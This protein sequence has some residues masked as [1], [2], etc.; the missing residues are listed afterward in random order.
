MPSRLIP[1]SEGSASE[2]FCFKVFGAAW[3]DSGLSFEAFLDRLVDDALAGRE[4]SFKGI[5]GSGEKIFLWILEQ[6]AVGAASRPGSDGMGW[7]MSLI[8]G[9]DPMDKIK[10]KLDEMSKNLDHI[11][12]QI[13]KLHGDLKKELAVLET[14]VAYSNIKGKIADIETLYHK[15]MRTLASMTNKEEAKKEADRIEGL[16]SDQVFSGLT[17]IHKGLG[18]DPVSQSLYALL[19]EQLLLQTEGGDVSLEEAL[20][21][22]EN[23]FVYMTGVQLKGLALLSEYW[24]RASSGDDIEKI[25]MKAHD[26]H[27]EKLVEQS[28]V[29]LNGLEML[30]VHAAPRAGFT[31]NYHGGSPFYGDRS[32][33]FFRA[34]ALAAS[35]TNSKSQVIVRLLWDS[36]VNDQYPWDEKD[37]KD[38]KPDD[39]LPSKSTSGF[40]GFMKERLEELKKPGKS[41]PLLLLRDE[42]GKRKEIEAVE[43]YGSVNAMPLK[44]SGRTPEN[45]EAVVRRYV[46]R[47]PDIGHTYT[48][49]H[50]T[51]QKFDLRDDESIPVPGTIGRKL[52]SADPRIRVRSSESGPHVTIPLFAWLPESYILEGTSSGGTLPVMWPAEPAQFVDDPD[53]VWRYVVSVSSYSK[54]KFLGPVWVPDPWGGTDVASRVSLG[55][56]ELYTHHGLKRPRDWAKDPNYNLLLYG[57]SIILSAHPTARRTEL[58]G[59]YY[60]YT[61]GKY[62]KLLVE[63]LPSIAGQFIDPRST[64]GER[65]FPREGDHLL[66][67]TV[68]GYLF[69]YP[70]SGVVGTSGKGKTADQRWA[71]ERAK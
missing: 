33:P 45:T 4:R 49:S 39:Y 21:K 41:G 69:A 2:A 50:E 35:A 61:A 68:G 11:E 30:I 40:F 44:R 52:V 59:E 47:N 28:A 1:L 57:D 64:D 53:G 24:H 42:E 16:I 5:D 37:G 31:M 60:F 6:I 48:V 29:F 46:F 43:K 62:S 17:L 34:D 14:Q 15:R 23:I 13:N 67:K 9:P 8:S 25:V 18:G 7:L 3:A 10:D 22:Y 19:A 27:I 71:L 51:A 65:V 20:A 32:S 36:K 66:L 38:P 12:N 70:R 54:E 63:P 26:D 56:T 58:G 55:K